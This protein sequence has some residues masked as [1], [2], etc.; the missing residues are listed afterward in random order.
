M[1]E[2]QVTVRE[3]CVRTILSDNS[4]EN[5]LPSN[6]DTASNVEGMS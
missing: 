1:D 5:K 6:C 4:Q 2:K 3:D